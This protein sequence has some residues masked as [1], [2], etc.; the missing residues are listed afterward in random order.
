MGIISIIENKDAGSRRTPTT[1]FLEEEKI[2][3]I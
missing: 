2:S 1:V 3:P